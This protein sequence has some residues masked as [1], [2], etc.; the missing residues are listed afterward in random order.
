[1]GAAEVIAFE[2]VRAR[3]Q[4]DA[5]RG[6]LLPALTSGLMGWKHSSKSQHRPWHR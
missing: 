5:L 4:W 2:E 1:M 6:Q 3:K